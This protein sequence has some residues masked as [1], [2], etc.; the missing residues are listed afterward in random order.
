MTL[1]GGQS[2]G[3]GCQC[4]SGRAG[5]KGSDS[6]GGAR[7]AFSETELVCRNYLKL[8]QKAAGLPARAGP[9][10]ASFKLPVPGVSRTAT[11]TLPAALADSH[12]RAGHGSIRVVGVVFPRSLQAG[13]ACH[14]GPS[15]DRDRATLTLK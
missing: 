13:A 10:A 1:E 2:S 9:Q 11:V 12:I 3:S 7:I 5:R 8:N 14:G 6:E 4:Q 15:Y